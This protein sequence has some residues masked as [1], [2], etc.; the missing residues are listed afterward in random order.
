MMI[1][2]IVMIVGLLSLALTGWLSRPDSPIRILDRPNERSLHSKPTPRT[3]GIAI[4]IALF[5]GWVAA[6]LVMQT[7]LVPI[8]MLVGASIIAVVALFDDRFGLSPL[9]RLL[10]QSGGALILLHDRFLLEG[11]LLPGIHFTD[12]YTMLAVMTV[13]LTLWL[14]NL[15]NFMDGIDGFAGGMAVIGFGALA[16][17]GG[18]KGDMQFAAAALM[19]CTATVGFLWFNYPP[20]RIFMGDSGS[21]TLGFLV[22]AFAVWASRIQV[23]DVWLTLMIFSP[24]VVDST[25]TLLRRLLRGEPVWRAHRSHYYQ[26]LVQLG[27]GHRRTLLV[28]YAVMLFCAISAIA[29]RDQRFS[30]QWLM[31]VVLIFGYITAA[32]VVHMMESKRNGLDHEK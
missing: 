20:A 14:T 21:T 18:L 22:A 31:L 6:W 27:W 17:L 15:Y 16:I 3:G 29:I 8:Q 26:R 24:F 23:A 11:E 1:G 32:V 4:C 2:I 10:V 7:P 25:V 19:I 5:G 28:E 13:I 9:T 12:D 30:T